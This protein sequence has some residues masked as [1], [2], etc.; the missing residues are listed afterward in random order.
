MG[1]RDDFYKFRYA[2]CDAVCR[3][4]LTAGEKVIA[5]RLSMHSSYKDGGKDSGLMYPKSATLATETSFNESY[6]RR[7]L[8]KLKRLGWLR[9]TGRVVVGGNALGP[10]KYAM[11]MPKDIP[12]GGTENSTGGVTDSS[13]GCYPR[14]TGGVTDGKQGVLPTGNTE[15][16]DEYRDEYRNKYYSD[17]SS[18][19]DIDEKNDLLAY[20]SKIAFENNQNLNFVD[21]FPVVESGNSTRK[22]KR[23]H[24]SWSKLLHASLKAVA[25]GD[26]K[27]CDDVLVD[28]VQKCGALP[29]STAHEGFVHSF[30]ENGIQRIARHEWEKLRMRFPAEQIESAYEANQS[31]VRYPADLSKIMDG[32]FTT[33]P[34]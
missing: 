25:G 27:N 8:T 26:C 34:F 14:V 22:D 12:E 20:W 3:S 13:E 18:N 31:N 32:T 16:R 9:S 7:T 10:V 4:D 28:I 21:V 15:Y 19:L 5:V 33:A 23:D 11:S 6:V 2:W 30:T 17:F 1:K 24:D 29:K